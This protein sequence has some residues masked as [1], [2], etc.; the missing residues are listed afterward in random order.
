M[1][2]RDK[3]K[4]HQLPV[5]NTDLSCLFRSIKQCLDRNPNAFKPKIGKNSVEGERRL[6]LLGED[7]R[8]DCIL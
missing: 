7:V 1:R 6:V 5:N 2:R 4:Y 3:S 8:L